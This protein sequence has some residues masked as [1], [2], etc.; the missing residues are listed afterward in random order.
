ME[1]WELYQDVRREYQITKVVIAKFAS[2]DLA[3]DQK[4]LL[5]YGR[6]EDNLAPIRLMTGHTQTLVVLS[7]SFSNIHTLGVMR[8]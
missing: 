7:K 3:T 8:K 2:T 5:P 1:L 4:A 6:Y